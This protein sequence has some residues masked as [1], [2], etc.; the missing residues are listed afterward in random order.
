MF[1]S[2]TQIVEQLE[3]KIREINHQKAQGDFLK[4]NATRL[5]CMLRIDLLFVGSLLCPCRRLA[6]LFCAHTTRVNGGL[7]L[8][9]QRART[10]ERLQRGLESRLL[11]MS[12]RTA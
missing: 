4:L 7:G 2:S 10:A 9:R 3:G 1:A 11:E 5:L 12:H 8:S 6:L